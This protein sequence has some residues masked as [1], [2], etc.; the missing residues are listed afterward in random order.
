MKLSDIKIAVRLG[1]VFGLV[2][3]LFSAVLFF[4]S[5]YVK[6]AMRAE[7]ESLEQAQAMEPGLLEQGILSVIEQTQ[8]GT[9]MLTG[10]LLVS[11]TI[12]V[13]WAVRSV[14]QPLK[15]LNTAV[16]DIVEGDFSKEILLSQQD[17]IGSVGRSLQSLQMKIRALL[18]ETDCLNHAILEGK[19]DARGKTENFGGDWGK[20]VGG[21]NAVIDA[22]MIPFNVTA[23]YVERLSKGD[24]PEKIQEDY[25]GDFNEIK[26]NLNQCLDSI[27]GL[28]EEMNFLTDSAVAGQLDA[29]GNAGK[30]NGEYARIV[31]GVNN[32]L[33]AVIGPLNV[34][35]EYVERIGKGDIPDKISD[36]Y[37]GDF[38][39]IKNNLNQCIN[40]INGL[41]DE[42]DTLANAAIAGRLYAR[43]DSNKFSGE[44]AKLLSGMNNTIGTL[45]G[46]IDQIPAPCMIIDR[47]FTIQYINTSGADLIGMTSQHLVGQKCYEHFKT[48][49]CQTAK[50]ACAR[51]MSV[52]GPE[53]GQTDAHPGGKEL[54]INYSGV[55]LHD[56]AGTVIGALEIVMDQTEVRKAML[57]AGSKAE[58]L[59]RI[60]TP[61]M[62]ID[63][64][65]TVQFMNPAGASAVGKTPE[66]CLKQKCF[67]LFNTKQCN[68]ENCQLRKA[69]QQD[70]VCTADTVASLPSGEIPI[71][72]TG[73]PL[74]DSEGN[75]IGALEYVLDISK[76][77]E[78]TA[79]LLGLAEDAIE[80][81]LDN[82]ADVESFSGNYRQ[83]VQGVNSIL[84][85]VIDPV[86]VAC[87]YVNRISL[88]DLPENIEADYRGKFGEVKQ[89]LNRLLDATKAIVRLAEEM[90]SGNLDLEVAERS[91]KDSLMRALK[92]M[93]AKLNETVLEVK[94]S[95]ENVA[96][97]SEGMSTSS[98]EM[99]QGATEQA[100][101]AEQ[102]SSS[103]EE[104]AAN[105]R[106]NAEN[107]LQTEKIAIKAA[108]DARESGKAVTEAVAAMREIA[109]KIAIIEDIARQTRL[110]SL[111]AT[112]EA[113][114]AQEHG[115]GFAVVASEVRALAERSQMA[116]TE[117]NQLSSS[118]VDVAEKAGEMLKQLVPDIQK[119]AEL[120]Q[121]ISA[122]SREQDS[123]ANQ[124]NQ[125]IQQLD[126][127]IQ[128]NSAVSEEIASMSEELSGQAEML[129]ASVEFFKLAGNGSE[130]AYQT[131]FAR[132]SVITSTIAHLRKG[133][134]GKQVEGNGNSA[135]PAFQVDENESAGDMTDDEFERF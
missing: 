62:V 19:L 91:E 47:D 80:G 17:E 50:C 81:K 82:R 71:R 4:S 88:G 111:N 130:A 93:L 97:G 36:E 20:L 16:F 9:L 22:F 12:V 100:A 108:N 11:S 44:Y 8:R 128:Q 38:N 101:A 51:A 113:A 79:G 76:E 3:I 106:Q 32:T 95:A 28:V 15:I 37:R 126:Q 84:D 114:K 59:N 72:Y 41:L 5:V 86:N 6:T 117:I 56:Q 57:D 104:M 1:S 21:F 58:Y 24:I 110:L 42:S 122:A 64:E 66:D 103:M 109:R 90:S 124:I 34:A 61:V 54:F 67:K 116:A 26:N 121:E 35:A 14:T 132:K 115:K 127:V 52:N 69:M 87:D 123:G 65:F 48:S 30:F 74:K 102:A 10:L 112:I 27:L 45:V 77:T 70:A 134:D 49:D 83:I 29:R 129:K 118:S 60:P 107:A 43:G 98:Q 133:A 53:G 105:I 25:Q 119:T 120:V 2:V 68:T 94:S 55:P 18:Q 89:S 31:Q 125:A 85:A 46:H 75:I 40:G 135:V 131:P 96:S 92:T 7:I 33:D 99:S 63:R 78:I 23:E 13:F 39:E 73:A